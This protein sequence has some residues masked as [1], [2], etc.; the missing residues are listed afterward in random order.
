[1][2]AHN[3]LA[4][5]ESLEVTS[6][7]AFD[8]CVDWNVAVTHGQLDLTEGICN[9]ENGTGLSMPSEEE[10]AGVGR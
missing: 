8:R 10:A 1:M 6:S 4:I 3:S 5:S 2:E 9:E 7:N